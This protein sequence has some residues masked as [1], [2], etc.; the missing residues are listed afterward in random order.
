MFC[1]LK[2]TLL[3]GNEKW[4]HSNWVVDLYLYRSLLTSRLEPKPFH[5]VECHFYVSF[6]HLIHQCCYGSVLYVIWD[7]VSYPAGSK[8]PRLELVELGTGSSGSPLKVQD[9]P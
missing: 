4:Q 2:L 7:F 3:V 5:S 9:L 1:P 8:C 6:P